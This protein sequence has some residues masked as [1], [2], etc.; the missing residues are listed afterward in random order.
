VIILN[1]RKLRCLSAADIRQALP[2]ADAVAVMKE[3]FCEVS[4]GTAVMPQRSDIA[5]Q[6]GTALFMPSY[7][8]SAQKIGLKVVTLFED[9]RIKGLPFIQAIVIVLDATNGSPIAILNGTAL[10]AIRTGAASGA[11]TDILARPD[12]TR[13]AIF[14]AGTQARTQLEAVCAVRPIEEA[15]V[16]DA[17]SKWATKFAEEMR[18]SLD[19][20]IHVAGSSSEALA[21]A[22]IVCT[23]T[24]SET[25]VFLDTELK[26]GVHI[27]AVGSYKPHTREIPAET[28]SRSRVFVDQISAAWEEAGDLIMPLNDGLI[29][30]DHIC[31]EIGELVSGKK[32]GRTN[33]EQVTF[34]KSVGIAIQDLAAACQALSNAEKL[35]LG[36][37]APPDLFK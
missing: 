12:A 35:G 8:P 7:S 5:A 27:N 32:K 6:N 11:A 23:A 16:N 20:D 31:G 24:I 9:N 15:W 19:I 37:F 30:T 29:T 10:T 14:G 21:Q 17:S 34:F 25:P 18:E 3:A 28:V 36:D 33:D 13:V 1:E 22:D 26:L 4:D 2:M